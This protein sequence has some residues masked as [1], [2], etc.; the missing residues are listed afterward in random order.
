MGDEHKTS[1]RIHFI[2][3]DR[4]KVVMPERSRPTGER[5][6]RSGSASVGEDLRKGEE[7]K[8]GDRE[9]F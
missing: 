2:S 7:E 4:Y 1:P 9:G 3:T 5:L 8:N 6:A